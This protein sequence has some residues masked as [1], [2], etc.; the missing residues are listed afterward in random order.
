[1]A[2]FSEAARTP[3][4]F[5]SVK[6]AEHLVVVHSRVLGQAEHLERKATEAGSLTGCY[7]SEAAQL[8][9]WFE[10]AGGHALSFSACSG[11]QVDRMETYTHP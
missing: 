3:K 2:P 1:M 10:L 8:F 4:H 5:G 7:F 11:P 9:W 6:M